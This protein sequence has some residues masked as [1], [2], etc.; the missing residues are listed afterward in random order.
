MWGCLSPIPGSPARNGAE[1]LPAPVPNP[2]AQRPL[3]EK[4]PY[5]WARENFYALLLTASI[6]TLAAMALPP[7]F[8]HLDT[9]GFSAVV[10]IQLVE[11]G[12]IIPSTV[13][14]RAFQ[15]LGWFCL[16]SLWLW[17]LTPSSM[18]N[19]GIPVLVLW[20]LFQTF[21]YQLL[22]R[23]L[24][25]ER[26]VNGQ[27]LMGAL[28]GYIL[29]GLTAALLMTSLETILPGSF[30]GVRTP[31][32]ADTPGLGVE[33]AALGKLS[34]PRMGYLAFVTMTTLGYGD[35]LPTTAAAQMMSIAF[36]V[37]GPFYLAVVMGLLIG[38]Y[39]QQ[40]SPGA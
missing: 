2:P 22:V 28:A 16:L 13:R 12:G 40:E 15:A 37:L 5:L 33:E 14:R 8:E 21:A 6:L 36:S 4:G 31:V 23:M 1:A 27:V 11:L 19:S 38:R 3:P 17:F 26:R 39:I 20:T 24:G 9:L 7:P 34:F 35:L 25:E 30:S 29:L 18:L 32:P 10:L